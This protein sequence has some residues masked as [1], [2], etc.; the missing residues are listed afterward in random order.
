MATNFEEVYTGASA[1]DGSGDSIRE[2][3]NKVN[4]NFAKVQDSFVQELIDNFPPVTWEGGPIDGQT[5]FQDTTDSTNYE[6]GS[7]TVAGGLGV[8]KNV[9]VSGNIAA[10]RVTGTTLTGTI[11]T[12]SQPNITTVGTLTN[13]NVAGNIAV[14]GTVTADLLSSTDLS[15]TNATITSISGTLTTSYQPNITTVGSLESLVVVNDTFTSNLTVTNDVTVTRDT[16]LSGNLSVAGTSTLGPIVANAFSDFVGNVKFQGTTVLLAT[17]ME[18]GVVK[19]NIMLAQRLCVQTPEDAETVSNVAPVTD[20]LYG[21][22]RFDA[23]YMYICINTQDAD[24]NP[25]IQ[26]KRIP[27]ES[28]SA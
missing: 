24:G 9:N 2:A 27:L 7:V 19:P 1:N 12:A 22:I 20:G 3:F 18:G 17:K 10:T 15:A 23:N 14:G 11:S 8:A 16:Q 25:D 5:Q 6:N 13:L 21:E 4:R 26:W 28:F